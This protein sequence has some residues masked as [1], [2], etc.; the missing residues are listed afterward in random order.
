MVLFFLLDMGE[1][2][3]QG[4]TLELENAHIVDRGNMLF[5]SERVLAEIGIMLFLHLVADRWLAHKLRRL[6]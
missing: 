5:H 6:G 3:T 2:V 1:S 4:G